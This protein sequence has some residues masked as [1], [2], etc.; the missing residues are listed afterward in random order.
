[1]LVLAV[2]SK[3]KNTLSTL[4]FSTCFVTRPPAPFS[5]GPTFSL[6]SLFVPMYLQNIFLLCFVVPLL[7]STNVRNQGAVGGGSKRPSGENQFT[8]LQLVNKEI[9]GGVATAGKV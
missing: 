1:M 8:L 5:N 3:V 6:A 2:K 4:T 7:D 9:I